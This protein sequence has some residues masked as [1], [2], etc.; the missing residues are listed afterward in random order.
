MQRAHVIVAALAE[1]GDAIRR[2]AHVAARGFL[3][4]GVIRGDVA[5]DHSG[6]RHRDVRVL[7]LTRCDEREERDVK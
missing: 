4:D 3:R 2:D 5:C 1:I 6:V 7:R